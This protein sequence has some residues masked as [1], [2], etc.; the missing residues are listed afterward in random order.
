[1]QKYEITN[2]VHPDN[3]K[4]FRIRALVDIPTIS[5]KAGDLGGYIECEH[6]LSQ[7]GNCW[8]FDDAQVFENAQVFGNAQVY[9][10]AQVFGQAEVRRNAVVY[11][12][13]HA[14]GTALVTAKVHKNMCVTSSW[15]ENA[16]VEWFFTYERQTA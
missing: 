12:Q 15:D 10:H 14:S 3:P 7:K 2:I 11:D 6:N 13:A 5:V 8:I 1:M 16:Y 9:G 4:L